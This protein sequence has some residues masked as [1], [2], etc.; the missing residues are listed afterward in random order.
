MLQRGSSAGKGHACA[1]CSGGGCWVRREKTLVE[2]EVGIQQFAE[3][4]AFG[5]T[6][7]KEWKHGPPFGSLRNDHIQDTCQGRNK[8]NE[9]QSSYGNYG[10]LD[11]SCHHKLP[12][13]IVNQ[14]PSDVTRKD[15]HE[16]CGPQNTHLES[17]KM[18]ERK[19]A[20]QL[21]PSEESRNHVID[22]GPGEVSDHT[23]NEKREVRNK[24]PS[25]WPDLEL[26]RKPQ[27]W[28]EHRDCGC[29]RNHDVE[30]RDIEEIS[31]KSL[32]SREARE[33]CLQLEAPVVTKGRST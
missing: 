24:H 16:C 25:S 5:P 31:G 23:R 12:D 3:S 6:Q 15:A 29:C 27:F 22:Q 11:D 28:D 9:N 19:G 26:Q 14:G 21:L 1:S 4:E 20:A 32:G 33:R 7:P 2:S 13:A 17:D 30:E 10:P 18:K 8:R